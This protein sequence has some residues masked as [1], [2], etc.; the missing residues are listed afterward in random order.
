MKS[1]LFSLRDQ[2]VGSYERPFTAPTTA[3]V[4]RELQEQVVKGQGDFGRFP[5]DFDLYEVGEWEHE[6]G[7]VHAYNA[8]KHVTSLI[9]FSVNKA[10]DS[11][12]NIGENRN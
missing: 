7:I 10:V 6:T 8:P 1:K 3:A 9:A 12:P 4:L 5:G 2:K 11:V